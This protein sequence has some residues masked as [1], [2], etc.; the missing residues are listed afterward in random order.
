MPDVRYWSNSG[1]KWILAGG[2]LV[3]NNI[4]KRPGFIDVFEARSTLIYVYV[5]FARG[6][7]LGCDNYISGIME[8]TDLTPATAPV[9]DDDAFLDACERY[10]EDQEAG[11][12][13][14]FEPYCAP[15]RLA[16][17]A[18]AKEA[19]T[20]AAKTP[21]EVAWIKGLHW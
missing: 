4:Q 16:V 5:Y 13:A 18:A 8:N 9:V 20:K 21:E 17:M 15:L 19:A 3:Y 7:I 1:Q 11:T 10:Q 2:W 12:F 6:G 14:S